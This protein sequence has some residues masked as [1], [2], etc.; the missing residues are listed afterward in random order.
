MSPQ[1]CRASNRDRNV[2]DADLPYVGILKQIVQVTYQTMTRTVMNC[3]WIRPNLAGN[4]TVRQ[5]EYG[6][7]LV[8]YNARQDPHRE[9]PYVFPYSVSQV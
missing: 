2:V 7:W 3:S 1:G 4:P 9:N 6:F 8:K 5:D